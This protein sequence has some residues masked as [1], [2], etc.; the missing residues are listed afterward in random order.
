MFLSEAEAEAALRDLRR[1]RDEL[2]RAHREHQLYLELGRRLGGSALPAAAEPTPRR[3]RPL[4]RKGVRRRRSRLH[5][6]PPRAASLVA[7]RRHGGR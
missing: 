2:D 5:R 6:I 1:R 4:P 3:G 7:A